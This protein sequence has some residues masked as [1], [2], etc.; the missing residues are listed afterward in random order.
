MACR[1]SSA[2]RFLATMSRP[3][4]SRSS[5][6]T[7]S[8]NLASGRAARNCSIT[9]NDTPLPPCT[10]T[11]AGLSTTSKASSSNTIGNSAPGTGRGLPG[12]GNRR[13]GMRTISPS[14]MR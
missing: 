12:S 8:R 2:L 6:C 9:P 11:P 5:R 14:T 1:A 10:A 4:V 13:G 7:S 3:E